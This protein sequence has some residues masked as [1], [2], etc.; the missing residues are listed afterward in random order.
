MRI[1]EKG[2]LGCETGGNI[3]HKKGSK[4]VRRKAKS[5]QR[6]TNYRNKERTGQAENVKLNTDVNS[7]EVNAWAVT[8]PTLLC[9]RQLRNEC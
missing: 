4:P 5:Q 9:M 6:R 8:E 2:N 1:G 7:A 3:G